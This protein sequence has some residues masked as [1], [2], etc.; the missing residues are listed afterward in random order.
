MESVAHLQVGTHNVS[1][2]FTPD[3]SRNLKEVYGR[4]AVSIIKG[5]K[6][7]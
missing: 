1:Y 5:F 3:D 7:I 2:C 6:R 4:V